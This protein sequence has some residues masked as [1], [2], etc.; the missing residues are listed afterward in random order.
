MRIRLA[1]ASLALLAL[2]ASVALAQ[3]PQGPPGGGMGMR[4]G[5][6]GRRLQMLL[7]G[8]TLT[9]QQQAAVDSIQAVYQPRM[10]AL[11]T[12]G[13]PP[14]STARARRREL[15]DSENKDIRA[16]LTPDQ[17]K[18]FDKNVAEMPPMGAGRRGPGGGQ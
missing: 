18:I 13:S 1:L 7:N 10:R 12:P 5:G 16:V 6:P 15:G 8:I 4:Q 11:F 9:A 3:D 2:S 14:D 17:Q